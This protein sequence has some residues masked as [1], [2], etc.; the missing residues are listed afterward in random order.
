MVSGGFRPKGKFDTNVSS[1]G[2]N[3]SKNGQPSRVA[4]GGEWGS[5]GESMA[6]QGAAPMKS[7]SGQSAR[8]MAPAP[9]PITAPSQLSDQPITDGAPVGDGSNTLNLP[10]QGSNSGFDNSIQM[11]TPVLNFIA[12]RETTSVETRDAISM[13]LRGNS[14]V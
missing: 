9:T 3:G 14:S 8:P 10:M 1:V 12:S 7:V 5:R 4:A 11:Y 2:G 13:L 6:T